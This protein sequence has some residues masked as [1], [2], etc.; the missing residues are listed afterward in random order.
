MHRSTRFTH[1]ASIS[2]AAL[3]ALALLVAIV[4]MLP[5]VSSAKPNLAV[6]VLPSTSAKVN[7]CVSAN[8]YANRKIEL[9]GRMAALPSA[10]GGKLQMRFDV[11]RKFN[12]SR[13][14]RL[15]TA[16]GL[17]TWLGN[18][19]PTATVYVRNI[20]LTQI[21][22]A[23][24]YKARVRY[25]WLDADG[26]VVAKKTRYTKICKQTAKL[27]DPELLSVFKY[28]NPGEPTT[29]YVVRIYNLSK[30]EAVNLPVSLAID[31]QPP[32]T[33]MIDSIEGKQLVNLTFSDL[34]SCTTEKYVRIDPFNVVRQRQEQRS[35]TRDVC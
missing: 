28:P 25:R 19:E 22:T 5:G 8:T 1:P 6:A 13:R 14:F 4:L 2:A 12:E 7:S 3:V 15:L 20:A 33:Q 32:A 34:P 21:E 29:T 27:P 23:T 35:D 24:Q 30:S 11:F 16:D 17:G 18:T 9:S 31:G 26:N 10:N